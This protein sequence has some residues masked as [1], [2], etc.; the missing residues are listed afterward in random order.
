MNQEHFVT[1]QEK[2]DF[3]FRLYDTCLNLTFFVM[4]I[5]FFTAISPIIYALFVVVYV[6]LVFLVSAVIVLGTAGLIFL[7]PDN[8]IVKLWSYLSNLDTN[9]AIALQQ[10]VGPV[11]IGILGGLLVL[12]IL[13][14]IFKWRDE[15]FKPIVVFILGGLVFVISLFLVIMGGSQ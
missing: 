4:F 15:K 13:G 6:L 8:F 3:R 2:N 1:R 12:S 14:Y 11:F 10:N 9:R 7:N 5:L